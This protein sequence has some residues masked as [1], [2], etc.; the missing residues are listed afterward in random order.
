M[1]LRGIVGANEAIG[2]AITGCLAGIDGRHA[3]LRLLEKQLNGREA[4]E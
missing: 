1:I 4:I 3:T 2:Q